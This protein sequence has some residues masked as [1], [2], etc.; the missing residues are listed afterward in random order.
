MN[1]LAYINKPAGK[2]LAFRPA[3][4]NTSDHRRTN[5]PYKSNGVKKA[6]TAEPIRTP[7]QLQAI[8]RYFLDKGEYRNYVLL[9]LGVS[10]A[11]R[12]GDLLSLRLYDVYDEYLEPRQW[13]T[14]YEDKT[15]KRNKVFI[16]SAAQDALR[17][18]MT[19]RETASLD[20]PLFPGRKHN[21]DGSLRAIN[22]DQVNAIF[23]KVEAEM[24]LPFHFSSHSMRK[25]FA[26]QSI[27]RS[28]GDQETLYTLQYIL[29]HE[30][31]RTTFRYSG[32]QEDKMVEL[33]EAMSAVLMT[34]ATMP[35]P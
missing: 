20:E 18:Y 29:N 4:D 19:V 6:T 10:F 17:F 5:S 7:E 22:I 21:A 8:Q 32:V 1:N 31:L 3:Q 27:T 2:V 14:L 33:R 15:N 23:R 16:N 9:T 24:E 35:R 13:V 12:C 28:H 30:D 26:Y 34:P 25:T 11:L